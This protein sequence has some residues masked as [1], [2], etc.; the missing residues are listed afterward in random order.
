M[1]AVCAVLAATLLLSACVLHAKSPLLGDADATLLLG[2]TNLTLTAVTASRAMPSQLSLVPEGRH[3]RVSNP[4]P[5]GPTDLYFA[6]LPDG[7]YAMQ[8]GVGQGSD[9]AVATW[10]GARLAISPLDC[11]RLKTDLRSNPLVQFVNNA[12]ALRGDGRPLD[13]L[14]VLAQTTAAPAVVLQRN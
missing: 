12:C 8:Y 6:A 10:D 11:A 2:S 14:A 5:G 7:R 1:K 3:Y 4:G 13:D 9:Y